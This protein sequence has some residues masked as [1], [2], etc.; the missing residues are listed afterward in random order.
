AFV[1][2]C[3]EW[4]RARRSAQAQ[5]QRQRLATA[6]A[7]QLDS[8]QPLELRVEA[9]QRVGRFDALVVHGL[10]DVAVLEADRG[11]DRSGTHA[12][13]AQALELAVLADGRDASA[14]GANRSADE[15]AHE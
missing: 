2:S 6:R 1:Y 3:S 15:V 10:Q 12:K 13:Q 4:L 8:V 5:G 9:D 14:A 11:A 7:G